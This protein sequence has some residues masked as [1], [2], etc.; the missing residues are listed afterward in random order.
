MVPGRK[1]W[2]KICVFSPPAGV[3][4]G[5]WGPWTLL[6]NVKAQNKEKSVLYQTFI[7]MYIP[8][9]GTVPMHP[10]HLNNV[11]F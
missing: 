9:V 5:A 6:H 10:V 2:P 4:E 8:V 1:I 3:T 11:T 7:R